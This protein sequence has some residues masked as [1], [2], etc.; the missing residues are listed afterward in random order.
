MAYNVEQNPASGGITPAFNEVVFVVSSSLYAEDDHKFIVVLKDSAGTEIQTLEFISPP[1]YNNGYI[2]ISRV[3][4]NYLSY[5]FE[6]FLIDIGRTTDSVVEIE[7]EFGESYINGSGT[8][9]ESL[10]IVSSTIYLSNMGFNTYDFNAYS[11]TDYIGKFLNKDNTELRIDSKNWLYFW[12]ESANSVDQVRVTANNGTTDTISLIT[13]THTTFADWKDGYCYLPAGANLNNILAGSLASGT[14]GNVLPSDTLTLKLELLNG[15]VVLDTHTYNIVGT[16]YKTYEAYY[17][18]ELG[19]FETLIFPK[20]YHINK[21]LTRETASRM[22]G[23]MDSTTSYGVNNDAAGRVDRIIDYQSKWKLNT[24][25]I[26]GTKSTQLFQLV[27]SPV[28]YFNDEGTI[29]R[30][31]VSQADYKEKTNRTD[32]LFNFEIEFSESL[33]QERQW[34]N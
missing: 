9:V 3:V 1:G 8:F 20:A 6:E 12:H 29:K 31:Q 5:N 23:A 27:S 28:I 22:A 7:A 30:V 26:D 18:T 15:A 11:D 4:T 17:L 33:K 14:A 16:C 32:R 10:N 25:W 19:A 24:D 21:M 34:V 13:N 2:D